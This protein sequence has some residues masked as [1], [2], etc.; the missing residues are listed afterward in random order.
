MYITIK[1][2]LTNE[3]VKHFKMSITEDDHFV[4]YKI[5]LSTLDDALLEELVSTFEIKTAAIEGKQ[6]ITLTRSL[7]V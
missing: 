7:E 4:N 5:D 2:I 6:Y 1:D 3:Q